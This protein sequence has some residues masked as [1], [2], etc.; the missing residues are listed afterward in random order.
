MFLCIY[1]TDL[2][3]H[4]EFLQKYPL[5]TQIFSYAGFGILKYYF[6]PEDGTDELSL[7]KSFNHIYMVAIHYAEVK[8]IT[9]GSSF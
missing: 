9:F 2:Y 6:T 5:S 3:L 8:N 7:K 4:L 1:V